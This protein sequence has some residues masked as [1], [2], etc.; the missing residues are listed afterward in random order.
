MS[1]RKIES[2]NPAPKN[3]QKPNLISYTKEQGHLIKESS[4]RDSDI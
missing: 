2:A 1:E 4:T 3:S